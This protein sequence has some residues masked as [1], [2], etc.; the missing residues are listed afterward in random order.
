[1]AV[2]ANI[3]YH[4]YLDFWKKACI[5]H[6]QNLKQKGLVMKKGI[7]PAYNKIKVTRTDGSVIE[8]Y[9]SANNDLVLSTD[10]LNHPAWTGQRTNTSDKGRRTAT[11]KKKFA[12]FDF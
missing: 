8:L 4:Y 5:I 2:L 3:N 10:N 7:H 9:S 1:M 12:G 11:F 6:G